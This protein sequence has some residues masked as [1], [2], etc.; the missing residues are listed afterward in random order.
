[1]YYRLFRWFPK[2]A[3]SRL[4]GTLAELR[5]PPWALRPVLALYKSFFRIDMAQFQEPP[6]G[7]SSFN[8]FFV[9]PLAAGAR[10]IESAPGR[11]VSP[12]DGTVIES[13]AIKDGQ[14]LQVKGQPYAVADLL[15]G[16]PAWR[17]YGG[18]GGT[19]LTLY[20]SPKDYHRIHSPCA[21][22]VVR[23]S[24]VPGELWTVS[25][26]GV[27]SVPGLFARN[28]RLITA[29]AAGFGE[30]LL[31]AVGA[32]IVGK[33]KV[34]YHSVTS[35]GKKAAPLAANLDRP[36]PLQRGQ[37]LGRFELGSTVIL[38]FPPGAVVLDDLPPGTELKMGQGIANLTG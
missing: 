31:V 21:G 33:I 24:Y 27:R 6:E 16:D 29:I 30:V 8:E 11:L 20:L 23:F 12:V 17:G 5:F 4:M 13:G 37:E 28:E 38:L 26:A 25:P 2:S 14:L 35:N 3:F 1:M 36:F 19:F 22:R 18:G 32:T 7:F 34:V 10:P 15:N 9:R